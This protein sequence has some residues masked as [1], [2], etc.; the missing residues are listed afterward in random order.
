MPD[1]SASE[2]TEQATPERLRKART[3]GRIA[4]SQEVPSALITGGVLLVL[5]LQGPDMLSWFGDMLREAITS[6]AIASEGEGVLCNFLRTKGMQ[7]IV[8]M[9]PFLIVCG[10]LSCF[11]S[12]LVSGLTFSPKALKFD[13]N[14][15]NPIKGVKNVISGKS[16]VRLVMSLAKMGIIGCICYVYMKDNSEA[17][18]KLRWAVPAL[19]LSR[20]A[21][22][23]LGLLARVVV[24]LFVIGGIDF[25]YQK[26]T[27]SKEMRM[28]KQEVKEERK[29]YEVSP[30]MKRKMRMIQIEMV[31]K[32]ML[33]EVPTAD[34]VVTNPTHYAVALK[35]DQENMAAPLVVAK[36]PDKLALKIREIAKE[37]GVPIVER[38]SLARAL[39]AAAEIGEPVP[40]NLFV[41]VAE[42][43]AMIFRLRRKRKLAQ[44]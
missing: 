15:V 44:R 26:W 21:S 4:Q 32:R 11:S 17:I 6:V 23:I 38:P 2:K 29:Q 30:E 34:V 8:L 12:I 10:V 42:L 13:F 36:G 28:T 14:R 16:V 18:L 25:A 19:T 39:Y 27:H 37:H 40:S 35:Y 20:I 33:Q 22:L 31:R 5:A 1:Q 41:A 3:E 9:V 43:L 7:S 24:A